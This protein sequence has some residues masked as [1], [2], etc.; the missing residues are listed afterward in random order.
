[1]SAYNTLAEKKSYSVLIIYIQRNLHP[2][3]FQPSGQN[4]FFANIIDHQSKGTELINMT[5]LDNDITVSSFIYS[6]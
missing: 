5:A 3:V 4:V 2:P 1:M 6:L